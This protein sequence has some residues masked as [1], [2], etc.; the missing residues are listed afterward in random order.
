VGVQFHLESTTETIRALVHH[1]AAELVPGPYVQSSQQ[2]L[3]TPGEAYAAGNACMD[4]LLE[5][6]TDGPVESRPV[7][8]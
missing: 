3:A 1:C 6:L 4:G 8:E 2:L 5:Y 7:R